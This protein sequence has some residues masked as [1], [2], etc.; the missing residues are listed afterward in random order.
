MFGT[1][2]SDVAGC[3]QVTVYKTGQALLRETHR[4]SEGAM[5]YVSDKGELYIRAQGGWR[6]IQV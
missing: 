1:L 2:M 5:A 6:K 3:S 4:A